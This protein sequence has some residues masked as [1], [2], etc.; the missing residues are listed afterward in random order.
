MSA[1]LAALYGIC[2]F[3]LAGFALFVIAQNPR[4][5]LN[6]C[7]AWLAFALLGWVASLFAFD[8]NLA[9]QETLW[10]GRFNF[11][12]IILATTLGFLFV[13]EISNQE[14]S[15][16][17]PAELPLMQ[18]LQRQKNALS[19]TLSNLPLWLW[20][21][22]AVLT[23]LSFTPLIDAQERIV[24][25]QHETQY[26]PLFALYMAHVF[27]LLG[28][29]LYR[30]FRPAASAPRETRIQLSLIGSG[31]IVMAVIALITNVFLPYAL[32][33]F[34][35]IHVGTLSTIFFLVA[36]G[37]AVFAHHLFSVHRIVRAA[38]VYAGLITLALELYQL[39]VTFLAHLLPVG[40]AASRSYAATAL[41]LVVN[42]FTQQS[43][44]R[45]LNR[46]VD[47][48]LGQ[49]RL[50][51]PKTFEKPE[52]FEK[53]ETKEEFGE[54]GKSKGRL[55]G[56]GERVERGGIAARQH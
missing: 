40:D 48:L 33:D 51:K 12:C 5:A 22:T 15:K 43:V 17:A 53:R 35:F 37:Y 41:A 46:L 18:R 11:A 31:I 44:R 10:I 34:R 6:R 32:M 42:A 56:K 3:G 27:A 49:G 14:I 7:F 4:A 20:V 28:A 24:H 47:R 1:L 16:V 23:V 36:V 2:L 52:A 13:Q 54:G 19:L 26:G 55:R 45:W 25:G 30:A 50:E 9:S 29:S 21:E 39:A 38:F 8:F